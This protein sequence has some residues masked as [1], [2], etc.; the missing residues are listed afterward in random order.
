MSSNQTRGIQGSGIAP[1]DS[2][3]LLSK[4]TKTDD[5]PGCWTFTGYLDPNGYGRIHWR[6][7]NGYLA[8]RAAYELAYGPVPPGMAVDHTC[9]NRA[10]IRFEHLEAVTTAENN[11]RAAERRSHCRAGHAWS[12]DNTYRW[13]GKRFCRACNATAQRLYHERERARRGDRGR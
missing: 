1:K 9:N 10:C 5:Q 13:N 4:T 8:H 7:K 6:G 11:R 2:T 3:R 12:E